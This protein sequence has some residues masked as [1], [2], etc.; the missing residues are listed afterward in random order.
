LIDTVM[1]PPLHRPAPNDVAAIDKVY[2]EVDNRINVL[3]QS[4][5]SGPFLH[6]LNA[7]FGGTPIVCS[8]QIH[9]ALMR[10]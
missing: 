8:P 1:Q 2:V 4:S 10:F 9:G 3:W 6:H 5:G 7:V